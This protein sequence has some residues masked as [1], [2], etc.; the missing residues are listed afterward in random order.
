[1][2]SKDNYWDLDMNGSMND[3]DRDNYTELWT[4]LAAKLNDIGPPAY[5]NLEWRRK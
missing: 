1:M 2:N 5:S 4:Q 3:I